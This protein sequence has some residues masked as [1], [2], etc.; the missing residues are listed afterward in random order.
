MTTRMANKIIGYNQVSLAMQASQNS[1][2]QV[3]YAI[4]TNEK[5]I[6]P[7]N[8]EKNQMILRSQHEKYDQREKSNK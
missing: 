7:S 4:S 5:M 1:T 6:Q 8:S 3:Y 2:T